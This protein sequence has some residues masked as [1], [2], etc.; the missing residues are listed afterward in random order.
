[1]CIVPKYIPEYVPELWV[2]FW[3]NQGRVISRKKLSITI[4]GQNLSITIF[5]ITL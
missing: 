2:R 3:I 4:N 5:D 1:M